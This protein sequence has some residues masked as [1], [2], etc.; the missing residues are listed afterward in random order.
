VPITSDF[1]FSSTALEVVAGHDLSGRHAVIT[2]A[3]S[4]LGVETARALAHAG[5][6]LTLPV[7]SLERGRASVEEIRASEP[8]AEIELV[9]MDLGSLASVRRA[10]AHI[11]DKHDTIHY[12]INNAGVMA[13]PFESTLDGFELQFG[14]NHLGHAALFFAL[15]SALVAAQ[16]ARVVALSSI[17]HRRS[18]VSL[19][20][21]NFRHR[22]YDKWESYGASKTA[23]S[24][25]AVG[26][27]LHFRDQGITANAVHP[28]GIMTGLQKFLPTEEMQALGWLNDDGSI[29][30]GFKTPEQ[31]AATSTWAAVGAELDGVGGLYLEDCREALPFNPDF[32]WAGVR[33]YAVDPER[34]AALWELTREAIASV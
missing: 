3:A 1:G 17:A 21:P 14:T 33:E 9:E 32:P 16:G 24:L 34:A 29:R 6:S 8:D 20:D 11:A 13:T 7:R 22:P 19:D 30:E 31:G 27:D 10:G 18:D 5:V 2:G 12:L 23:C 15:E 26:V 4:G 25:F 28:G